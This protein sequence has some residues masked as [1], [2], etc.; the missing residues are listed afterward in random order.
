MKK[1]IFGLSLLLVCLFGNS[2]TYEK[3]IKIDSKTIKTGGTY[4]L[5]PS[6][7]GKAIIIDE[8]LL[9]YKYKTTPYTI[10]NTDSVKIVTDS[11]NIQGDYMLLLSDSI[12][13]KQVPF[14]SKIN[15]IED[16]S[17]GNSIRIEIPTSKFSLGDS[18]FYLK[19]KYTIY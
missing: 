18:Y 12:F 8:A 19:F 3:E 5:I 14:V 16:V 6:I 10:S 17:Y 4:I 15:V 2:Q 7:L 1:I 13:I 9:K 11:P